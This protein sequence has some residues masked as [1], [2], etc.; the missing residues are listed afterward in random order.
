M[1]VNSKVIP[2]P[3]SLLK[4]LSLFLTV[5]D[6]DGYHVRHYSWMVWGCRHA[7]RPD[8]FGEGKSVNKR[9]Q[10][11]THNLICISI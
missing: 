8:I 5:G 3:H 4:Y 9:Y 11:G 6:F 10:L 1:L 7:P 2:L